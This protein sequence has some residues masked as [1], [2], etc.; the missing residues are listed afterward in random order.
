MLNFIQNIDIFII[1]Q[2]YSFQHSLNSKLLSNILIFFTNL[3]NS[4]DCNN[5]ISTF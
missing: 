4:M 2:F 5:I 1:K 3:G